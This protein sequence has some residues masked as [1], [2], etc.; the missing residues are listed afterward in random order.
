MFGGAVS[1]S[2]YEEHW[3]HPYRAS[4]CFNIA[5]AQR[6]PEHQ[7]LTLTKQLAETINKVRQTSGP[8]MARTNAAERLGDIT[9]KI[10]PKQVDN[11]TLGDLIPPL[12]TSDDSV[13]LWVAGA[14][15]YLG[16]RA[17]PAVPK[18]L[19]V[20]RETTVYSWK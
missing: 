15:G 9:R 3:L 14:L 5:A 18:L 12:N 16:P 7:N 2:C 20:M 1:N 13:R 6:A 17:K 11:K 4:L 19:E 8:S 10:D